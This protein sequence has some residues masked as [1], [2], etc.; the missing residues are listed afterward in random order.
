MRERSVVAAHLAPLKGIEIVAACGVQALNAQLELSA[1]LTEGFHAEGTD[2]AYGRG[3]S[4]RKANP[5]ASAAPSQLPFQGSQGF[6]TAL[7]HN[8]PLPPLRRFPFPVGEGF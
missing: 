3:F 4:C 6:P 7:A 2:S 1:K 8:A 5:S